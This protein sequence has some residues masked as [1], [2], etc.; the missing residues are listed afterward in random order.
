VILWVDAQLS[1]SLAPWITQE[2]GIEAA[3]ARYLGLVR[4]TDKEIFKAARE[5][6]AIVLTKDIDF[7]AL[8]QQFGPPPS[9]LWIRCGNTS[10]AHVRRLL[11]GTLESALKMIAAASRWS[12]LTISWRLPEPHLH[13]HPPLHRPR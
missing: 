11:R 6:E 2:F 7:V 9:I 8:L 4:T 13:P 3:S 1:P 5:A 12:R 10:N